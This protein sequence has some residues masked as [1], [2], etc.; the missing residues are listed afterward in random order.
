MT[1]AV[2][3]SVNVEALRLGNPDAKITS[4][5]LEVLRTIPTP[6]P[7]PSGNGVIVCVMSG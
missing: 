1:D 2:I 7:S 4:V 6:P 5:V 3:T